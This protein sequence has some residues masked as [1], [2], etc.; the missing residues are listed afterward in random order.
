LSYYKQ[1]A[2][3]NKKETRKHYNCTSI[4][5]KKQKNSDKEIKK[6]KKKERKKK[7]RAINYEAVCLIIRFNLN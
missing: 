1:K 5:I 6:K 3:K 7:M 4:A 2:N